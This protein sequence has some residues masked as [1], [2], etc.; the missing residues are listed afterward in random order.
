VVFVIAVIVVLFAA[1]INRSGVDGIDDDHQ[2]EDPTIRLAPSPI[3]RQRRS[4]AS[5]FVPRRS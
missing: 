5:A 1:L 4:V 3:P 2:G